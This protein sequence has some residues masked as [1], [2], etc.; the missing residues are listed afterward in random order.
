MPKTLSRREFAAM[1]ATGLL[2]TVAAPAVRA[3]SRTVT[4]R[5]GTSNSPQHFITKGAQKFADLA[6]DK[7]GGS[8]TIR[9][10]PASQL[11]GE[12]EMAE[13]LKTGTIDVAVVSAGVLANFDP[14]VGILD[15]KST[16][17]NSSHA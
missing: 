2:T 16:R 1:T 14:F 4:L 9:V 13:G 8:V 10:F 7:S 6:K 11:G 5:M 3:Q 17:L 12:R 15:R